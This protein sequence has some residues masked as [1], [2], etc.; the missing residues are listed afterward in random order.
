MEQTNSATA[1]NNREYMYDLITVLQKVLKERNSYVK[2]LVMAFEIPA[3]EFGRRK[4]I[5][6]ADSRQ[7]G[8]HNLRTGGGLGE[9]HIIMDGNRGV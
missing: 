2:D 9:I 4:L 3:P 8:T 6:D 7:R 1:S 5:I